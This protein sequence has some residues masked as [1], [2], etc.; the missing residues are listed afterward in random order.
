MLEFMIGEKKIIV[1]IQKRERENNNKKKKSF[2][3]LTTIL[4][5]LKF[6]DQLTLKHHLYTIF[7]NT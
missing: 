1:H 3:L 4:A 7:L 2:V 6:K 5:F